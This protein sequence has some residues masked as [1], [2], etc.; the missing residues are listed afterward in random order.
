[1]KM[2]NQ[3]TCISLFPYHFCTKMEQENSIKMKTELFS[4][5]LKVR[6]GSKKQ[7]I[8]WN[9]NKMNT[10]LNHTKKFYYHS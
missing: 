4:Q 9:M 1:M 10:S 2:K 5:V 8:S 6:T 3:I 7:A